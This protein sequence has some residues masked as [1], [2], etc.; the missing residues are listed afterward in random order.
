MIVRQIP[1]TGVLTT[2]AYF[3]G[4]EK[5]G[6][7]FLIDPGAEADELLQ[8]ISSNGW[9]IEK[10]LLTH[11]HFDHIGAVQ[12]LHEK[13]GIPYYIEK[14][15]K[16]L[17]QNPTLN[18]SAFF[19]RNIVLNRADFLQ[20]GDILRLNNQSKGGLKVLHV[21]GHTP[22]SVVYHDAENAVAFVGDTIFKG[23]IG[24][25]HFPLGNDKQLQKSLKNKILTLPP[26]TILYSGHSEPTTVAAEQ[27]NPFID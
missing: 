22:D 20:E 1:L 26:Q 16:E 2:N 5:S 25:T 3:Y 10:I 7:G 13:L 14:S 24:A 19:G 27:N 8:L 11:G 18:L 9:I 23:S 12:K 15:G 6:H 17:L 21:P 4:D